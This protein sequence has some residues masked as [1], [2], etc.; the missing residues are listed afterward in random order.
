MNY[1][2]LP[3]TW[4]RIDLDAL[5]HNYQVIRE[6]LRPGTKMMAVVKADAYG[7][8]VK[9]VAPLLDRLGAEQFAV[10]NIEEAMQLRALSVKKPILILGYTP[11]YL[12]KTLAQHEISQ[13]VFDSEYAAA[14]S[15][16]ATADGVT[17]RMHIKIDTGMGRLGF[18]HHDLQD[19]DAI[20]QIRSVCK[21][22]GLAREGI[23]THFASSDLDGDQDGSFTR[24]QFDLFCDVIDRLKQDGIT[25]CLR[26]CCNSAATLRNPEMQLDMVRPGIILYGMEP[27]GALRN[28]ADLRPAM[29]LQSVI[30][31]VKD[32]HPGDS[33]SY[34]RTYTAQHEIRAATIPIGYA[35]GYPRS[36][37]NNGYI[38]IRGQKAPIIG[39][40]CMDQTVVDVTGIPKAQEGDEVLLFGSD[41]NGTLPVE[42][43]SALC[44]TINYETVCLVGK[45]V[46]RIYY[47]NGRQAGQ[48]NYVYN[49]RL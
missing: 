9:Y 29:T 22:P 14:L 25:F 38:L 33:V 23:F 30:S 5:T 47:E 11:P 42:E 1:T 34:G 27:S 7:H 20:E 10:S 40:V 31:M 35:D 6:R 18:I 44:G 13:T 21:L 49:A 41:A 46:P 3:R 2:F 16:H 37:S 8:G 43:Y 39:R 17:V 24:R 28:A 45:R 32:L 4:A 48:L 19:C 15:R 26:H 12:A 36:L